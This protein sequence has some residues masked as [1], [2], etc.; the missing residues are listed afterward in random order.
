MVSS[1]KIHQ[2]PIT[3][4][5]LVF[6]DTQQY[7][8]N[9]L[10]NG[11]PCPAYGKNWACPPVSPTYLQTQQKLKHYKEF[12][13]IIYEYNLL[14][15]KEQLRQKH[16]AWDDRKLQCNATNSHL[17]N[18]IIYWGLR[19]LLKPYLKTPSLYV[20]ANADCR[21]CRKGCAK[22]MQQPCRHPKERLYSME[23]SGINVDAT[24]R[25]IG[26]ILQWINK[27]RVCQVGLICFKPNSLLA[28]QEVKEVPARKLK[29]LMSF[30]TTG[31]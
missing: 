24:L 22:K 10:K 21:R 19:K 18:G 7:C 25:N 4:D 9:P 17:Y 29:T 28:Q 14:A 13:V 20:L 5:Q 23:A 30:L 8:L 16:P 26:Y 11:K 1:V 27:E 31:D 6:E 15:W 12:R 3:F 2:L